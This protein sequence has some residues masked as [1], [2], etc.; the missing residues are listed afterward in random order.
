MSAAAAIV[1]WPRQARRRS[2][3]GGD[4]VEPGTSCLQGEANQSTIFQ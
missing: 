3:V 2:A 4:E 1:T